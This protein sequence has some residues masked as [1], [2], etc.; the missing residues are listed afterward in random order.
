MARYRKS[1][2]WFHFSGATL[3]YRSP[4]EGI[5]LERNPNLD[6][7]VMTPLSLHYSSSYSNWMLNL[8]LSENG[9][10]GLA[11]MTRNQLLKRCDQHGRLL[12]RLSRSPAFNRSLEL[13][14]GPPKRVLNKLITSRV[15]FSR[16]L[17]K[18]TDQLAF[19]C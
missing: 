11:T 6:G 3:C 7:D 5:V 12:K 17:K 9:L 18:Y 8:Q 10:D 1:I 15:D 4:L 13:V 16:L 19:V 14:D 2:F